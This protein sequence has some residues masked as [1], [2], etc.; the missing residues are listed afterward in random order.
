LEKDLIDAFG[1]IPKPMQR[2]LELAELRVLARRF[3]ITSISLQPPDVIFLVESVAKAQ[4][5][6]KNAPGTVRMPDAKTIHL[7]LP[8]AYLEPTTLVP[9]LRRMFQ[10]AAA[11]PESVA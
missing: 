3:G 1:P 11:L 7:R 9:V 5:A 10:K 6:F 4:P 8:P 2:L